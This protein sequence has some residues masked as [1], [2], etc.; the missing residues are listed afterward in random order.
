MK[1]SQRFSNRIA[2]AFLLTASLRPAMAKDAEK[3]SSTHAPIAELWIE[4]KDLASRDLFYG[5]G[6][7]ELVPASDV[8]YRYQSTD[9][10]G[11]S[12]GYEVKDPRDREWKIKIGDEVQSELAVSRIL[13]AIGYHQ[14][15]MHYVPHWKMEGSP[16]PKPEPGRFRLESDHKKDG[17]W[18]WDDNPF[19]SAQAFRGLVVVNLLLNNWDLEENNNRVYEVK[20]GN[21]KRRYVVQDLGGSLAKTK[22]PVGGRNNIDGYESQGFV[23]K[24]ADGHLDFDYHGPHKDLVKSIT[25]D[26]VIW[27]CRLVSR[28]SERQLNDAFRA[29]GYA[30]DSVSRYVRKIKQKLAEGLALSG[31]K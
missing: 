2:V 4:P 19:L 3:A 20:G 26:D 28:L 14:P 13:W 11:H 25:Q 10:K 7:R 17:N 30:P 8:T 9:K 22:W 12:G 23:K 29:A 24:D 27:A 1:T 5:P 31:S 6:G 16:E 21:P 15:V 18:S